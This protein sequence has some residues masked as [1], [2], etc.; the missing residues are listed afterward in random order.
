MMPLK[1]ECGSLVK[2]ITDFISSAV[3]DPAPPYNIPR[4]T[5]M[6]KGENTKFSVQCFLAAWHGKDSISYTKFI[7]HHWKTLVAPNKAN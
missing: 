6:L 3:S 4:V 5:L 2:F 7:P 1:K